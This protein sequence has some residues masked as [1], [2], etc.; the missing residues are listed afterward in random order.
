VGNYHIKTKVFD[1]P[2]DLL[3]ALIEKRKLLINDI[4]LAE[5]TDDY[6]KHLKEY[7]RLPV[8]ETAQFVLVGSTLLLIK[9]KSLLPV[10]SLTD[11][12]KDS[13]EDLE[14]RLKLLDLYK[15]VAKEILRIFGLN[16]L[17]SKLSTRKIVPK[18]S[19]D[20]MTTKENMHTAMLSVLNNLPKPKRDLTKTVVKKVISLEEMMD[21]LSKRVNSSMQISFREFSSSN[22]GDK[23]NMIVSF[24]AMLELVRQGVIRVEQREKFSD[25]DMHSDTVDTPSYC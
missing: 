13:I 10:I 19:P 6:L 7:E 21:R 11:E 12:E 22:K 14:Y 20:K 24:L 25:I 15:G 4:S 17:Y 1:G 2:L 8:E 5:V 16:K 9:S 23:L 3:L 18:F